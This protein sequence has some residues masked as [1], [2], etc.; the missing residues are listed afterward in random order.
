MLKKS[1]ENLDIRSVYVGS[2]PGDSQPITEYFSAAGLEY[3]LAA[4]P[5]KRTKRGLL[6]KFIRPKGS[7]NFLIRVSWTLGEEEPVRVCSLSA[8]ERQADGC[9]MDSSINVNKLV[10]RQPA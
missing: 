1:D 2:A 4:Q 6:Q 10:R 9:S 8:A 5:S 3:F 7:S